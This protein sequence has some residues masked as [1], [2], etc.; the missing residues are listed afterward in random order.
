MLPVREVR[1]GDEQGFEGGDHAAYAR[2]MT[3]R[4]AIPMRENQAHMRLALV[5]VG[6]SNVTKVRPILSDNDTLL[7]LGGCEDDSVGRLH[8]ISSFQD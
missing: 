6:S 3:S 4:E 2:S 8:Q 5:V 1:V 7:I